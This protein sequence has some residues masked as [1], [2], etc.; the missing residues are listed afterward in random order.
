VSTYPD[1]ERVLD[2][3]SNKVSP[4]KLELLKRKLAEALEKP[5]SS[6]KVEDPIIIRYLLVKKLRAEGMSPGVIQ[7]FEQLFMG[8]IRRAAINGLLPAPPEGPWTYA[9]QSILDTS[10]QVSGA[11]SIFRSL[12]SW[13]TAHGI[14]PTDVNERYLNLWIKDT[15]MNKEVLLTVEKVFE[16]FS[17]KVNND[18]SYGSPQLLERLQM[19]ALRGTV[20]SCLNS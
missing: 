17:S 11:K 18:D 6:Y 20:R 15:M 5:I 4:Q 7:A 1:L 14:A 13:A 8:I 2:V 16:L 12:A 19:K 9:W 10:S 3:A